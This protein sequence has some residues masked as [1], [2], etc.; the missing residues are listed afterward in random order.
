MINWRLATI[1]FQL[2]ATN[3]KAFSELCSLTRQQLNTTTSRAVM[4]NQ[5][6]R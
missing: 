1:R 2:R 6:L 3:Q 4:E 5:C